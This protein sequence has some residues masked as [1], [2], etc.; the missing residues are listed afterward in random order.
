[1][2][3]EKFAEY[4]GSKSRP[5][6]Q[7]IERQVR[8]TLK[9]SGVTGPH[10]PDRLT[11]EFLSYHWRAT[12]SSVRA[13][14]SKSLRRVSGHESY[15]AQHPSELGTDLTLANNFVL[16]PLRERAINVEVGVIHSI[17]ARVI[18]GIRVFPRGA[19]GIDVG[20]LVYVAMR[21]LM[22]VDGTT[23]DDSR[24]C[25]STVATSAAALARR[26]SH[27]QP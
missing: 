8:V 7:E 16:D 19:R 26:R 12:G 23:I 5:N 13:Q 17:A 4:D 25:G 11:Q 14:R 6:L 18:H 22:V 10:L 3:L 1:V 24:W 9:Q 2:A 15:P 20:L 27:R 21:Q